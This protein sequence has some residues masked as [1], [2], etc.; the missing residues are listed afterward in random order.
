MENADWM[1]AADFCSYHQVSYAFITDLAYAGL[2][3]ITIIEEQPFIH[4]DHLRELEKL[5]RLHAQLGINEEGIEAIAYLLQ[6]VDGLQKEIKNLQQRLDW[7][8]HEEKG[9]S[10]TS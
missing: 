5:A 7:Y 1:P 6:R 2:I 9:E 10:L 8:N 4:A 3:E